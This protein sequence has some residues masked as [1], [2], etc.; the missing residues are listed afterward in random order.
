MQL[1]RRVA[2][3]AVL[4]LAGCLALAG[5]RSQPSTAIY[6]GSTSYR[7]KQVD[8]L[9]NK[10]KDVPSIGG[11]GNARHLVAEW[12]VSRDAARGLAAEKRW[13][14]PQVNPEATAQQT[15]LAADDPLNKLYGEYTAYNEVLLQHVTAGEPT[16]ADWADFY[17]RAQAAGLLKPGMSQTEFQQAIGAQNEQTFRVDVRLRNLYQE[18]IKKAN[19]AVNPKYG[20]ELGLLR[21]RNNHVLVGTPFNAKGGPPAVVQALAATG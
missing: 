4:G 19:V 2:F 6:V 17:E 8:R 20:T 9:A 18:A 12:I 15:G 14:L 16:E 7:E 5:C 1:A 3:L 11:R 21:D 13:P 10:L